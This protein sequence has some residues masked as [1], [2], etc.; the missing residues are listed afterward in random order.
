MTRE[1]FIARAADG[2]RTLYAPGV[3]DQHLRNLAT[4]ALGAVGA[5]EL[6]QSAKVSVSGDEQDHD[7]AC[8]GTCTHHA[9]AALRKAD[10]L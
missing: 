6:Y 5:W 9:C 10:G 2:M 4:A 7:S 1:E 8:I 3:D